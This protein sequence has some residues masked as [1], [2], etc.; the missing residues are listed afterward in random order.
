M[1]HPGEITTS[2]LA[3]LELFREPGV[4]VI[5]KLAGL[6]L[7][8]AVVADGRLRLFR[9]LTI[10]APSE[11]EIRSVLQPTFAFVEDELGRPVEKLFICGSFAPPRGLTIPI[12]P[13]R[14]RLGPV[15]GFNAGLLGYLEAVG[16]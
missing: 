6:V 4:A 15:N 11:D 13:L 1:F 14:S 8:V 2:T 10:E 3:A 12:E 7:T 9:C 5:A 16:N